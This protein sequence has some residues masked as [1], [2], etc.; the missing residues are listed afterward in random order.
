MAKDPIQPCPANDTHAVLLQIAQKCIESFPVLI[1]G[2]G[3]S[4]PHGVRGMRELKDHLLDL[5]TPLYDTNDAWRQFVA[6]L[7]ET[8]DLEAALQRVQLPD[9][10]LASVTRATRSCILEDD[11]TVFERLALRQLAL[12]LT[13]LYKHL[14][15]STNH[16]L[17]VVTTN[18]DRLAEF[19][20]DSAKLAWY[21][22]FSRGLL[23]FFG[24]RNVTR[25]RTATENRT[26]EIWKV[27][28][29][30]DW[31]MDTD[32]IAVG[33]PYDD[34]FP[35]ALTPL[36]VTPGSIKYE[37]THQEP[38]RTIIANADTAIANARSY[39]CIGYGFNDTHIQPK[40]VERVRDHTTPIV[41]LTRTMR[42]P[43]KDFLG[44]C[45]KAPFLA[46]EQVDTA[47]RVYSSQSPDGYELPNCDLWQ[48]DKFLDAVIG[49]A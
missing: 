30:V 17:S 15:R 21:T 28:G 6:A 13:R 41:I 2:S 20:A 1:L 40:L 35:S 10:I 25:Q 29:S 43:A 37:A 8:D 27:H 33:L 32:S 39:L 9:D 16:T 7:N 22:G 45:K 11:S 4:A 24:P 18:Y 36:L 47:T 12:P 14:L 26:V 23:R 48:L 49:T 42:Q 31:F 19:A 5:L 38:F 34:G 44:K 46:L 3:A